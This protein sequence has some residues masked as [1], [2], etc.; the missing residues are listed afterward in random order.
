MEIFAGE[1]AALLPQDLPHRDDVIARAS[2]H[3]DLIVEANQQFNLTRITGVR[4]AAI[5]HV[6]DSVLPWRHFAGAYRVLDAGSGAGFPGIPLALVLPEVKFVL[7]ESVG[8]KARFIEAAVK[9]LGLANVTVEPRRA[10]ECLIGLARPGV[11]VT[12]RAVAPLTRAVPLFA[13]AMK[14][15]VRALLYKGPDS[16]AEIT[17]A[18]QELRRARAEA[19]VLDRYELPDSLGTRTMVEL[20]VPKLSA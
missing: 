1:L 8:K 9:D 18:A 4:D 17:E 15:G 12:A 19:K 5:K 14:R 2:R 20:H 13:P 10:E 6:L 3:L 16:E 11:I 7:A